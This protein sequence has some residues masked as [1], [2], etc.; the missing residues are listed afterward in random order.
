LISFC[1]DLQ[2]YRIQSEKSFLLSCWYFYKKKVLKSK[3]F[4]DILNRLEQLGVLS[5]KDIWISLRK[6]VLIR[7]ILEKKIFWICLLA[8]TS[9]TKKYKT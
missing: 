1:S 7:F 2:N 4:L 6:I 3:P 9:C 8:L 5:D